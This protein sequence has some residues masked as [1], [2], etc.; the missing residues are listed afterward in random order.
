M[1]FPGSRYEKAETFAV[2]R[3]DGTTVVT[4][5]L[6]LPTVR[7]LLG[8]HQRLEGQRLDHLAAHYLDDG[9]GFWQLCDANNTASPDALATRDLIGI[10]AKER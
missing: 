9:N 5:K 7:P 2:K 1:F 10:P 3:P 4:T 8:Y 6:P